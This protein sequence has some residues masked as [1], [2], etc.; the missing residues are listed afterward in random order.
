MAAK[1]IRPVGYVRVSSLIQ[2]DEGVSL[3]NQQARIRAWAAGQGLDPASVP[4]C[5]DAG[6]SGKRAD[7]RPALAEALSLVTAQPGGVLVVYALS[8]LARSVRDTLTIAERLERAEADLVSL[9]ESID[10]ASAAGK[11]VFRMLSVLAEFERDQLVE[12]TRGAVEHKRSKGERLGQIPFGK[13]LAEDGRT[14]TDEP[15]ERATLELMRRLSASGQ[16][17]GAIAREL[18]A[19]GLPPKS[20]GAWSHRSVARL[21]ERTDVSG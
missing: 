7:N 12:R 4:V 9:S 17:V 6:I 5:V 8:R 2:V 11:M 3:D 18:D 15:S 20:G 13:R 10:T 14:L 16:G 19:R 21:L 1:M